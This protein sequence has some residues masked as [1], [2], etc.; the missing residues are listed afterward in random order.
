MRRLLVTGASGHLGGVLADR[1]AAA[2]WEVV[3]TYMS[4]RPRDVDWRAVELDVRDPDAVARLLADVR[5]DAVIHSAYRQDGP[6]A[7]ATTADGARHV[8][9]A[10]AR[11]GSRLVHMSTD[12]VFSGRLGRPLR[13]DDPVDPITAYG[14]AK[15]AAEEAVSSACPEALIVRTSLIYGGPGAPRSRHEEVALLAARGENDWTFF[16]DE[17]R[18]P[19]QVDDLAVAL[20][21]LVDTER[22][23][24][25]HLA[26]PDAVD[27]LELARMVV[28]SAG[29]DPDRLRG[30]P[31]TG[32]RPTDCRLDSGRAYALLSRPPRGVRTVLG[33]GR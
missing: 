24:V 8:A 3:G 7:W 32:D 30:G 26:G 11:R 12:V 10:A 31:S 25:L 33:A 14:R 4:Q 16:V 2:G 13:E 5:P 28:A 18:C 23:G 27:R 21:E 22:A 1:A 6:D 29:G 9:E 19:I 17:L 15:V 20:L